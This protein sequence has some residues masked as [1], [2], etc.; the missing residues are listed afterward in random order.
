MG[1]SLVYAI[2]VRGSVLNFG[3]LPDFILD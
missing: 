1:V 3:L 2:L